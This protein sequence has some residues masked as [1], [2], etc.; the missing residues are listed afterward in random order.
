MFWPLY[1][2]LNHTSFRPAEILIAKGMA[3]TNP[4]PNEHPV[5]F[6]GICSFL[7]FYSWILIGLIRNISG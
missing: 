1:F 5:V 6:A 2:V 3:D 4:L 7:L